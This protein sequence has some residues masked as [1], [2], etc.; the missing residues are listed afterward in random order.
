MRQTNKIRKGIAWLLCTVLVLGILPMLPQMSMQISAAENAASVFVDGVELHAGGKEYFKNGDTA[1]SGATGTYEDHSAYY[2]TAGELWLNNLEAHTIKANGNLTIYVCNN[3]A[4]NTNIVTATQN[5]TAIE[6]TG[7]LTIRYGGYGGGTG[8]LTVESDGKE[9]IQAGSGMTVSDGV[10]VKARAKSGATAI[11]SG[12]VLKIDGIRTKLEAAGDGSTGKGIFAQQSIYVK[13]SAVLTAFGGAAYESPSGIDKSGYGYE[14]YNVFT[15]DA[16]PGTQAA[17]D[18]VLDGYKYIRIEPTGVANVKTLTELQAAAQNQYISLINVMNDITITDTVYVRRAVTIQSPDASNVSKLIRGK[19]HTDVILDFDGANGHKS[20]VVTLKNIIVDGNKDGNTQTASPALKSKSIL[21]NLESGTVI[22]NNHAKEGAAIYVNHYS[23]VTMKEGSEIRNN[24]SESDGTVYVIGNG[25]Y[26]EMAGGTISGNT[27]A[28]NGGGIYEFGG[29]SARMTGGTISGN[30]A[31]GNG[32]GVYNVERLYG[33]TITGNSTSGNGGG[34]FVPVSGACLLNSDINIS[35][36]YKDGIWSTTEQRYTTGTAN[37]LYL[38]DFG[39]NVYVEGSLAG[40]AKI[41]ITSALETYP[42]SIGGGDARY[43]YGK[44]YVLKESDVSKFVSDKDGFVIKEDNN[45]LFLKKEAA[46]L[47]ASDFQFKAPQSLIYNGEAKAAEIS[48]KNGTSC[49]DIT[50][51]YYQNGKKVT[52]VNAGTYI[53]KIN[54]AE[55]DNYLAASGLTDSSWTFTIEPRKL[56]VSVADV[57]IDRGD[58]MPALTV[59]V[60]GFA[61]GED[62]NSIAGFQKP[63]AKVKGTVNTNDTN[64][65]NFE[66]TY[67]GGKATANYQFVENTIAKITINSTDTTAPEITGVTNGKTYCSKVT[68][69]VTDKDLDTVKLDGKKVTLKDDKFTVSPKSGKQKIEAV[70]KAGNRTTVS[71]TVNDGHTAGNWIVDKKAT[72]EKTGSRHKECTVCGYVMETESIPKLTP[73]NPENPTKP[74]PENPTKP[75]PEKPTNPEKPTQ[76][77]YKVIEGADVTYTINKD[78]NLTMRADSKYKNFKG[79]EIDGKTV[80]SKNYTA[81]SG[82]TYV[83]FKK[84]FVNTLSVGKHTVKFKFTDGYATTS[85]TI[86]KK[87]N[88][89]TKN[90][91]D[92]KKPDTNTNTSGNG[93]NNSTTTANAQVKAPKTGDTFQPILWAGILCVSVVGMAGVVAA[94]K[95][96]KKCQ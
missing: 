34:V 85:L 74:D 55:N 36:N 62:E 81:W 13:N 86:A 73:S 43:I 21:V 27:V 40:N 38:S 32:G 7:Y 83:K 10:E 80:D 75:D 3:Q 47:K 52:P 92:N 39:S 48:K 61:D 25:G 37:N 2:D 41:G 90:P 51:E 44:G 94:D 6:V 91:S 93:A 30:T 63:T 50:V 4:T 24:V 35:G 12:G 42:V 9:A 8:S 5:E 68:V 71:I 56:L 22:E 72:V 59:R 20:D 14:D 45:E 79:I 1:D 18:T 31:K 84:D 57:V 82:S 17:K 96:R 78:G 28:G 53:A 70:D 77:K 95:K 16:A 33:G 60:D 58:A 54:V 67:S 88:S 69:T 11:S 29:G 66:V 65:K 15:G 87:D 23:T 76:K 64:V 26:F 46:T 89:D 49:G 19:S